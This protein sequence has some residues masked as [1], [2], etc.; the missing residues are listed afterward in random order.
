M[1]IQ[2]QSLVITL[3]ALVMATPAFAQRARVERPLPVRRDSAVTAAPVIDS[4]PT[5]GAA[6]STAASA[7]ALEPARPRVPARVPPPATPAPL[8]AP[9]RSVKAPSNA[10]RPVALTTPQAAVGLRGRYRVMLTGM[11][12][13]RQ[14]WDNPL[15]LDGKGDE[16]FIVAPTMLYDAVTKQ[17]RQELAKSEVMG[18]ANGR[19]WVVAAG[20]ASEKGGLLSGNRVPDVPTPWIRYGEV[21]GSRFPL[22]LWDGELVQGQH[23]LVVSAAPWEWDGMGD[24][25][26]R[27]H[28][29]RERRQRDWAASADGDSLVVHPSV[30][31]IDLPTPTLVTLDLIL[32]QARDRPIG[33]RPATPTD[34]ASPAFMGLLGKTLM[35]VDESMNNSLVFHEQLV[36]LTPFSIEQALV[37][38]AKAGAVRPGIIE[39][40]F[41]DM[42]RLQGSYTLYLQVERLP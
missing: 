32:G 4:T 42:P 14:S 12:V 2:R 40:R 8:L 23:A 25:F 41:T 16:I 1:H 20:R 38:P 33:L 15:Q 3:T 17:V 34:P 29:N 30:K 19:T 31:P 27:W 37:N 35:Q 39:L 6:L 26:N 28:A 5:P 9:A 7:P 18:D 22:L 36:V 10:P 13:N 21:S 11:V 24:L